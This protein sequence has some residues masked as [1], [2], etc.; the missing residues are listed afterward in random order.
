[1]PD[2]SCSVLHHTRV[3]GHKKKSSYIYTSRHPNDVVHC[4]PAGASC[5]AQL[6]LVMTD[7]FYSMQTFQV[8]AYMLNPRHTTAA[9]LCPT[10]R[11]PWTRI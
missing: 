3:C 6:L 11:R 9:T 1:M 10:H 7:W 5:Y 2:F 4:M 8:H